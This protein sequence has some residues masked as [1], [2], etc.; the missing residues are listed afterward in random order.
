[1]CI[2]VPFLSVTSKDALKVKRSTRNSASPPSN[3]TYNCLTFAFSALVAPTCQTKLLPTMQAYTELAMVPIKED[4]SEG[5]Q[6]NT[7]SI[8]LVL[9]HHQ[10]TSYH[11]W[12]QRYPKL[13]RHSEYTVRPITTKSQIANRKME[14][15][16]LVHSSRFSKEN[17][18]RLE[19][20][21]LIGGIFDCFHYP[22][23][24]GEF[25]SSSI[26]EGSSSLY[27]KAWPGLLFREWPCREVG[28]KKRGGGRGGLDTRDNGK[29]WSC[30]GAWPPALLL[31][32]LR[33]SLTH[34]GFI[35]V[36]SSLGVG[37]PKLP[38][39]AC[40]MLTSMSGVGINND[41]GRGVGINNDP[42]RGVGINNDPGC[43]V[44][45][46]NDPGCGVGIN[47]DLGGGGGG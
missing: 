16:E 12:K 32:I 39:P 28:E 46:N 13:L 36:R 29:R 14:L 20:R 4:E 38:G 26:Q 42:G 8:A 37:F 34:V 9:A 40:A 17:F 24:R 47:N 43:G 21:V 7:E 11:R 5:Q 1:M 6:N 45:I 35:K 3:A 2:Y 15:N 25:N 19:P 41:P 18:R 31:T 10:T 22:W 27:K 23:D 30:E 33:S 44:G